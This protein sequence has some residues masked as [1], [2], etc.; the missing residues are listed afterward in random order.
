MEATRAKYPVGIQDFEKLITGGFIYVDK[1]D[2][3]YKMVNEGNCYFLSRPRRFGKSL[4]LS[5]LKAYFE[6]K[7]ELFEGLAMSQL[8]KEWRKHPVF[9]LSFAIFGKS[10][11]R[12]LESILEHYLSEWEKEYGVDS[13]KLNYETRFATLIKRAVEKT[14]EKAVVLIDEYDSALVSTMQD[15]ALHEHIKDL[16]KPVYTVLKDY[17][18]YIRFALLTGITRF[19]RMTI[20]SG[21]NNLKDV[22]LWPAYSSICG[23]TPEELEQ[24]FHA[25]IENVA[26]RYKLGYEETLTELK[27][28]Y[29]GYHFSMESDD[30]YNPFSILNALESS[31]LDN[32]W[33]ATGIPSFIVERMKEKDLDLEKYMNQSAS[34]T[35]L[36]EAD[37]AYTSDVAVLFQAGFLTIKGYDFSEKRYQLGIP[38]R[39]VREGMSKLFMEKFLYPDSM[40]GEN[41]LTN[42]TRALKAGDPERFLTLLKAFFAGVPFDMSKGSKEVYFHNAFYIV[43]NL[44]GLQVQTERHTSAGSIDLVISTPDYVYVIEIKLNKKPQDA[45]DQ[46]NSKEYAL[47]WSADHRKL[48]KIGAVFSTR[49]RTLRNWIIE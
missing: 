42:M 11:E 25:G 16:L 32:Y 33:F 44:I 46:I 37:S 39:E 9:H 19:S 45:L 29:D 6:G 4:T 23:I 13:V 2:I 12:S 49:T 14:G 38:N 5:T 48:F 7:K 3:L 21:L 27:N 31:I 30:I 22:S 47:P 24:Y 43:T 40:E 41:I 34:D 36:K 10:R 35:V 17:D 26:Q 20:F 18:G 28:Y 8:E 15:P 1:T